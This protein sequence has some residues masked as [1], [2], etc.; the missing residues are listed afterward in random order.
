VKFESIKGQENTK[1]YLSGLV[2]SGKMPHAF[3]FT[4]P[5]GNGKLAMALAFAT[6]M[7][8]RERKGRDSCGVCTSCR[9]SYQHIHPDI[10]FVIPTVSSESGKS[11]V[12]TDFYPAWRKLLIRTPFI[13]L[14]DWANELEI[15]K[16]FNI[17]TVSMLELIKTFNLKIYE[18]Q[19]KIAIIWQAELMGKEGNRL[20]KLIEE[21]PDNSVFL[22]VTDHE[23]LLLNTIVSRCQMIKIP[24]FKDE[25]LREYARENQN[26]GVGDLDELVH[27]A[28]GNIIELNQLISKSNATLNSQFFHWLRLSYRGK[29][30]EII[31]WS[32]SFNQQTHDNRTFF[33]KYGMAFFEQYLRT[34]AKEGPRIRLSEEAAQVAVNMKTVIDEEK[35]IN[36]IEMLNDCIINMNRNANVKL[37]MIN[38]SLTLHRIMQGN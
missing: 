11:T 32:E 2:D 9:K 8:C 27:H 22:I 12:S 26:A 35:A 16:K 6:Y 38:S 31:D 20:L 30:H 4:G 28:N 15:N 3:L 25:D 5:N 7:Q 19:K 24:P 34:F 14:N 1:A 21:P 17:P 10:H 13:T 36:I 29:A 33:Y 18:G 23:D 37:Q